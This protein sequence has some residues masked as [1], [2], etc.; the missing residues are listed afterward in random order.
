VRVRFFSIAA[1]M[2]SR[3][4]RPDGLDNAMT[5]AR[6]NGYRPYLLIE[7]GEQQE[8]VDQ[9]ADTS[10][11]GG[12]G[13]PPLVDINHMLKIYDPDDFSRYRS[14]ERITTERVWTKRERALS[15]FR[16]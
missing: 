2:V 8:F 3:A 5:F 4:L 7:T 12:L 14:G 13:W 6:A 15:R 10:P 11:L 16:F 1:T 9:F